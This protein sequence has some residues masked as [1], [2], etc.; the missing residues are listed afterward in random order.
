MAK[1]VHFRGL[2]V[3]VALLVLTGCGADPDEPVERAPNPLATDQPVEPV[4]IPLATDQPDIPVPAGDCNWPEHCG[5]PSA[6]HMLQEILQRAEAEHPKEGIDPADLQTIQLRVSECLLPDLCN[7]AGTHVCKLTGPEPCTELKDIWERTGPEK[8]PVDP[9]ER[10]GHWH[11]IAT[12][13]QSFP[14]G[15]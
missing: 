10:R 13:L 6:L 15:Q 3:L 4:P 2:C 7:T 1:R 11:T 14:K 5:E 12:D 8:L 9:V